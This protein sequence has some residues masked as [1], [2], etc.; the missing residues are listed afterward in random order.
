LVGG[1]KWGGAMRGRS[2]WPRMAP[3]HQAQ[4]TEVGM[5]VAAAGDF[6][7]WGRWPIGLLTERR[8]PQ[9]TLRPVKMSE[10]S[11]YWW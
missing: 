5:K 6:R 7:G 9:L 3:P 8:K 1:P 4:R 2:A 10:V 11:T